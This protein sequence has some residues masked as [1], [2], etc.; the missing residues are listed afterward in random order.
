MSVFFRKKLPY[1]S[2]KS[3]EEPVY[4]ECV[5]GRNRLTSVERPY[6]LATEIGEYPETCRP[7]LP[8]GNEDKRGYATRLAGDMKHR[9][10]VIFR[11]QYDLRWIVLF[12]ADRAADKR[13]EVVQRLSHDLENNVG[14]GAS[15]TFHDDNTG[16]AGRHS[17]P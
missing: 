2:G 14:Y 7:H 16:L 9:F 10:P 5:I 12:L 13:L 6:F 4:R 11:E 17:R 15:E 3:L 8:E 1:S